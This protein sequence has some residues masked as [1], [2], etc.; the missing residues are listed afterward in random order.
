MTSKRIAA[1]FSL[2]LGFVFVACDPARTGYF[3]GNY[4]NPISLDV[5][6]DV[7]SG[8]YGFYF[9]VTSMHRRDTRR[10]AENYGS[11]G[12]EYPPKD[13]TLYGLWGSLAN[14]MNESTRSELVENYTGP[15]VAVASAAYSAVR[16]CLS[17]ANSTSN[18]SAA[19]L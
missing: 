12:L 16:T 19:P 11:V 17:R 9:G 1:L 15:L 6:S 8:P 18:G 3:D 5:P 4:P 14:A 7:P 2:G 10:W 13:H